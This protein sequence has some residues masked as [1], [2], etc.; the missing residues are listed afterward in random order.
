MDFWE[1]AGFFVEIINKTLSLLDQIYLR[2][3]LLFHLMVSDNLL[4][5][6]NIQRRKR[7]LR[8]HTSVSTNK[9]EIY[10]PRLKGLCPYF[11]L[12]YMLWVLILTLRI[13]YPKER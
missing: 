11:P 6:L 1:I 7:N 8:A 3:Q 4:S 12:K 10:K 5:C 13:E 9:N 2:K